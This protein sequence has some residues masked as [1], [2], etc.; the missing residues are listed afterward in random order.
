MN[1]FFFF[2]C[3][4]FH[5]KKCALSLSDCAALC[6]PCS[7]SIDS[8]V[9]QQLSESSLSTCSLLTHNMH[10]STNSS[11]SSSN[12]TSTMSLPIQKQCRCF[13]DINT[14]FFTLLLLGFVLPGFVWVSISPFPTRL[15]TPGNQGLWKQS[16]IYLR[17]SYKF[18]SCS[19]SHDK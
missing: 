15:R 10:N 2:F 4:T 14:D 7:F 16:I 5:S 1:S 11:R 17:I 19:Q 9:G 3:F 8:V 18:V 6:I 12:S 13:Q